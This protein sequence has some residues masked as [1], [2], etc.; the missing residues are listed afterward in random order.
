MMNPLVNVTVAISTSA[1]IFLIMTDTVCVLA[2]DAADYDLVRQ[3]DCYNV[4]QETHSPLEV[5]A[6]SYD[7]PQTTEIWPTV[8]TGLSPEEHGLSKDVREWNNPVLKR[9]SAV[10]LAFPSNVRSTLGRLVRAG[11]ASR[12]VQSTDANDHPF[13]ELFGWPGLTDATHLRE[14]WEWC[15]EAEAGNLAVGELDRRLRANTGQEFGWLAAMSR[16][17]ASVVGVHSHVLDV[18]GH[19]Y[20]DE[21]D[22]LRSVYKWVDDLLGWLRGYVDRLVVLSDHGI[23]NSLCDDDN[24]GNHSWRAMISTQGLSGPL[25]ESV[26]D[27]RSWLEARAERSG[28][29]DDEYVDVG[30]AR[31]HLADLG[32]LDE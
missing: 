17:D 28:H 8:A 20:A 23:R 27:V 22:R 12:T 14:A 2:L 4:L 21:P 11:G 9:L 29:R 1:E 26:Y 13:D 30:P 25:P 16:T 7:V 31:E 19:V 15:S 5:Y 18:A 24:L 6:H 10:T 32:Y 3:L